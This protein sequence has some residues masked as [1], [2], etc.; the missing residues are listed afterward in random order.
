MPQPSRVLQK[1]KNKLAAK[2]LFSTSR[3][4]QSYSMPR[5]K[6]DEVTG[7]T[8]HTNLRKSA[9]Y[10]SLEVSSVRKDTSWFE[11]QGLAPSMTDES[12]VDN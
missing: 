7:N 4:F 10:T 5:S 9:R 2:L 12:G 1:K 8:K 6:V 11:N 3:S